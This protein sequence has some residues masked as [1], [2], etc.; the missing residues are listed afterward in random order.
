M[1]VTSPKLANKV[2]P[3]TLNPLNPKP[4]TLNPQVCDQGAS[5]QP[6]A[7]PVAVPTHV[8]S[9]SALLCF[10]PWHLQWCTVRIADS[11]T[12]NPAPRTPHPTPHTHTPNADQERKR[13]R[14]EFTRG[15]C[16]APG[17]CQRCVCATY[18][19]KHAVYGCKHRWKHVGM[20]CIGA[21][22]PYPG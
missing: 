6:V 2:N 5:Q 19:C 1:L 20:P 13:A 4:H 11:D 7:V 17:L 16:A 21:R 8:A 9:C 10:I 12:L 14:G 3:Q 18:G 15:D 22:V